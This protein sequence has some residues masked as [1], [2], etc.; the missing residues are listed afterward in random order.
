[1]NYLKRDSSVG[2]SVSLSPLKASPGI[3]PQW[4]ISHR[5]VAPL[6]MLCDALL[7][8]AMGILSGVIYHLETIGTPGDLEKFGG[9]AAVVAALFIALGKSR[10]LYNL[11]EL[12][13][14]KFQVWR[15]EIKG[16]TVFLLLAAIAFRMRVGGDF[17]RGA[18]LSFAFS[19]LA[20]LIGS[21]AVW[22]I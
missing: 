15:V 4:T 6:V 18:T 7:I 22:R 5:A 14:F 13:N 2:K 16:V 21:R 12:L 19:G 20:V 9:F 3:S 1:M 17:S 11:S 10:N 8:V